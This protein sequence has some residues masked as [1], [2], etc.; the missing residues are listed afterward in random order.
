VVRSEPEP[1]CISPPVM[2]LERGEGHVPGIV[3]ILRHGGMIGSG[4]LPAIGP[5]QG[6]DIVRGSLVQPAP[7]RLSSRAYTARRPRGGLSQNCGGAAG[8]TSALASVMA[9]VVLRPYKIGP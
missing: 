8:G 5:R 3:D 6:S 7:G 1:G 2:V 9:G 4:R